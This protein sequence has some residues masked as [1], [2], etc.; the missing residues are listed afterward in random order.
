MPPTATSGLALTALAD[1]AAPF[2]PPAVAALG[3]SDLIAASREVAEIRRRADAVAAA[4]AAEIAHRSRRELGHDGLAQRLGMRTPERLVQQVSGVTRSEAHT[5]VRVGELALPPAPDA[6]PDLP[7]WLGAVADAVRAGTLSLAAADAIRSGLGTPRE[8]VPAEALARAAA[9]LVRAAASLTVE[10][11]SAEARAA[12]DELDEAGIADRARALRERRY[13]TLSEQPDGM[14]RLAGLLD[15]ESAAHVRAAYDAATSPRR[16]G[17]RFVDLSARTRAD[18]LV[19][20]TRTTEQ[21]ACD[22]LVALIVAGAAVDPGQILP[23]RRP[24]VVVHVTLA[25]LDR[26]RHEARADATGAG[27]P[28]GGAGRIEGSSASMPIADVERHVCEAGAVPV[29]FDADRRV[30]DVG[31]TQRLFTAR[32]R[33]ALAARDGGCRFPGCDRPPSWCESHH[34]RPWSD[35]GASAVDNGVLLCRH[36]HL[37]VHDAGWEITPPAASPP[38][39]SPPGASPP[40]WTIRPPADLDPERRPI[41]MPVHGLAGRRI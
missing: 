26:R 6:A 14:T 18:A 30:V 7:S 29:V 36:H 11:L 40:G 28:R 37:L 25:D 32:Q 5:F 3:D 21:I 41:P 23:V 31:R 38:G 13:L 19:D 33:V 4:V 20:D 12:R 27:R 1:V 22:S 15:P 39:A 34:V 10:K 17:P 2:A 16:G 8:G 9:S 24:E 35:G